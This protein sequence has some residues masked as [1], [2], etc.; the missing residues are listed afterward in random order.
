[1]KT[2]TAKIPIITATASGGARK[3]QADIPAAR[4]ATSSWLRDSR[5]KAKTPPSSTAKGSSFWPRSGSCSSAMPT[6]TLV[7]ILRPAVRLIRSTMSIENAS[8]RNAP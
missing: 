4:V 8:I 5:A 2:T 3:S 6:I 1:M 7:E